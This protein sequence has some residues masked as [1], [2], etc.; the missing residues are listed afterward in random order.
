MLFNGK[1][2]FGSNLK[3]DWGGF[4]LLV[5]FFYFACFLVQIDQTEE[6]KSKEKIGGEKY[7][8]SKYLKLRRVRNDAETTQ[9][10]QQQR[11]QKVK[12]KC[13]NHLTL[14]TNLIPN[15]TSGKMQHVLFCCA[16]L[17][18]RFTGT[19]VTAEIALILHFWEGFCCQN[20]LF[21]V[22]W[23]I[24]KGLF[25]LLACSSKDRDRCFPHLLLPPFLCFQ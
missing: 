4:C 18:C 25:P 22:V 15:L 11:K 5:F 24:N 8:P 2:S 17:V 3:N 12:Q 16:A 19:A 1:I 23:A 6:C 7:L 21:Y 10:P 9:L 14:G 20:V 13:I